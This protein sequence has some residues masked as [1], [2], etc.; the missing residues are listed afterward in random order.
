MPPIRVLFGK[1]EMGGSELPALIPCRLLHA[2]A[3]DLEGGGVACRDLIYHQQ[4]YGPKEFD[5][6]IQ[7]IPRDTFIRREPCQRPG[8]RVGGI[9]KGGGPSIRPVAPQRK[10]WQRPRRRPPHRRA[11]GRREAVG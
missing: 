8:P 10:V 4:L 2:A 7:A 9:L 5:Q 11:H 6:L 3:N 1:L